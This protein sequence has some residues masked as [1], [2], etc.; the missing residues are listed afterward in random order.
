LHIVL[1][2][3]F[4][5]K[6][7]SN[8]QVFNIAADLVVNQN[9]DPDQ[10][11]EGAV[12]LDRF[13]EMQLKTNESINYYYNELFDF[14]KQQTE[15]EEDCEQSGDSDSGSQG[16]NQSWENLKDYLRPE[17]Q[18]QRQHQ[19]WRWLEELSNAEQEIAEE[20]VN[21]TLEN[22]LQRIKPK[23][24]G[25]LPAGLQRY[26]EAFEQSLIPKVNWRRILRIFAA[27]SQKTY[28]KNTL[29]RPS[30]RYGVTPG[31]KIKR[32]NKLLIAIDTSGSIQ[33]E[34]LREFFSE[35][36]HIWRQGAEI[37]IVECDV[38]I[39]RQ[40]PYRGTAPKVIAGGGGTSFEA[41]ILFANET[42]QP[43]ALIYFTDGYA[44]IPTIKSRCPLMW[45]VSK[46]GAAES[47]LKDFQGRILKMN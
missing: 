21:Q 20:S 7:F 25:K 3:I 6:D 39:H 30:K 22:T 23:D 32:K 35:V 18:Y 12:T 2:H 1:K 24:F 41:P 47:D 33:M 45:L 9:I 5:Y 16:T 10:L 34:E 8:K 29:R 19:F 28:L 31:I 26:L 27:S 37:Y 46:G 4:R 15:K 42:Y 43:D 38:K 44:A 17:S 13:P 14:I 36:Y 11:I 40:Y